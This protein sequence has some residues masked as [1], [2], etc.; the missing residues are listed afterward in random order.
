MGKHLQRDLEY[1][2]K[3]ILTVGKLVERAI[4][5]STA[6]LATRRIDLAESVIEG[7]ALIDTKE[8][9]VE[10]D[11]LK[12]LALHQ[13]VA[14]D[15]RF[16]VSVLKVNND[17]ERMGD[18]AVN[19]AKRAIV[20]AGEPS[21][22]SS[23]DLSSMASKASRLVGRSLD[24]L[25]QL[26]VEIARQVCADDQEVDDAHRRTFRRVQEAIRNDPSTI[27]R[28]LSVLTVSRAL[29]RTAD[30]ATNI[31]EDVVFMVEGE[32]IRH[33]LGISH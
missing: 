6:A 26:D 18:L 30:L 31:A 12:L 7:D 9:K 22:E 20:L 32:V 21:L 3:E 10:D 15:L 29:E 4:T 1:L 23:L 19:I 16:V 33:G 28:A 5:D 13:P 25:V 17:L 2:K 24:A 14:A 27:E 11:C 8:V